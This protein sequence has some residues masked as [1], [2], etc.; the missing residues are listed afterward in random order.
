MIDAMRR[1]FLA[2]L[3][4]QLPAISDE[5]GFVP[6]SDKQL[7]DFASNQSFPTAGR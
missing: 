4:N 7:H 2:S 1:E 6:L 3:I 5:N